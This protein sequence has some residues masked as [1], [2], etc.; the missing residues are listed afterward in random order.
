MRQKFMEDGM[1]IDRFPAAEFN[2]YKEAVDMYMELFPEHKFLIYKKAEDDWGIPVHD[3]YALIV[4]LINGVT[5][6]TNFDVFYRCLKAVRIK[7]H[8]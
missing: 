4:K 8:V 2:I 3:Y 6:K 1:V 7:K 5:F